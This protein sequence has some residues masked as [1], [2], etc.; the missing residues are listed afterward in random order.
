MS[1]MEWNP[2]DFWY[3]IVAAVCL[4]F[5]A[6]AWRTLRVP[7]GP[8]T[9]RRLLWLLLRG[10]LL[11]ILLAILLN[12][13]QVER[14]E[15]RE[16]QDV[17]VLLDD[18]ASMALRDEAGSPPRMDQ[19][20]ENL[21]AIRSLGTDEI[22][23]RWYRFA[24]DAGQIADPES[25]TAKGVGSDIGKALETAL[26]DERTR[27]LGAAILVSDGQTQDADAARRAARFFKEAN[28]P[29][30][31]RLIGTPEEAPDVRLS[32][33][34]A[35]QAS[36]Y[37]AEVRLKGILQGTGFD[38]KKALLRVTCEGQTV[39]ESS[40]SLEG[41]AKPFE[42]IFPTPF[43]GFH[44]YEVQVQPLEGERLTENN[45]GLVG[46]DVQD[47]KIRVIYMEGTP[48]ASHFLENALENDPDIE[49]TSLFFPQS[50]SF[51]Q[52]RKVPFTADANG[53][54]IYNIAHPQKGYPKTLEEMLNYDVI[55][56]SDIYKEAFTPEQLALTVTLVEE[57]GG[58][59]VMVGGYTAF[60]KGHYD[61]TVIDK[62]MPVDV[63]GNEGTNAGSFGLQ[64]PEDAL[65][66]P[67]MAMGTSKE[68][69]ARVWKESF[70]GF[71]G[72]NTVNRPKPGAKVL[73]VNP[74]Q[75]NQYGPLVV[76]AVQQI[77]RG[78]TMAFTS[79]TTQGW[80]LAFQK[81]FGTPQDHTLY[82]RR[83]WNQS[84]RWLA[85]ERIRRKSGDLKLEVNKGVAVPGD[86]IHL[87]I[88]FPQSDP[89]AP[90]TLTKALPG[91]DAS[92]VELIRDELTRTWIAENSAKEEGKW[93][94]TARM[95][96]AKLDPL[97]AHALVH[98][99]PDQREQEST[100]ANR[101]LM[102]E[103]AELGG[104]RL[105]GNDPAKWFVKVDPLGSRIVE[106]G[107]RAV[108]DRWWV[109]SLLIALI[110]LEWAMRRRW[111]GVG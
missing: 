76:F 91:G 42:V 5:G 63:Y 33:V 41:E 48:D 101:A 4:L 68:E 97:F 34:S 38:G 16:P 22:R 23:L 100:A 94:Y 9:G 27:S 37:T 10:T 47:R 86:S 89:N 3:W 64:V 103:L 1:L 32:G 65:A 44:L 11:A 6:L 70:P 75:S 80:G 83:F 59:F 8:A 79:D 108:W 60:G 31:T 77:G 99:V 40:L 107:Q 50:E 78:R 54:K 106:Y 95:E 13:H 17:A 69:T 84:I 52:S 45:S 55:I 109:I 15:F 25:L 57:Y 56:N 51:E 35:A 24:D 96:Q 39:H 19:L 12:P 29:L 26:G 82:Y 20:K 21:G 85:A 104:G 28:I 67:I 7:Q 72:L 58:G 61:E 2:F 74:K 18:S 93:I 111:I 105:L 49:V 36:L 62:L 92:P 53:R 71:Y 90:V 66:H 98:V 88:P 81:D 46:V 14:R 102:V 43:K 110:T 73:A 87:R 30:Y